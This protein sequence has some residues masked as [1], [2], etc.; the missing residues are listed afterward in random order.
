MKPLEHLRKSAAATVLCLLA[1]A[2]SDASAANLTVNG[3]TLGETVDVVAGGH[4]GSVATAQLDLT[5]GGASGFS[6]CVDLAQSIGPGTSSG[7]DLRAPALSD[8]VIRA[9][10]LVDT[11]QPG[12]DSMVHPAS[13][14]YAFGVTHATAI[15]ALQVAVWEVM[16]ESPGNYDLYSGAFAL[17]DGGASDGVMNLSRDFLGQ[18][19]G[20]DLSSYETSALW[21]VHKGKQ[22]QLFFARVDPIPEPGTVGLYALAAAIAAFA[23]R[24]KRA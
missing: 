12:L 21:A 10:W 15:A 1:L 9:A 16:A 17:A 6:Y 3:W 11:F 13:D 4:T 8:S 18:L 23:L 19:G 7:W 20:A 22:D 24:P 14:D 2:A 5:V